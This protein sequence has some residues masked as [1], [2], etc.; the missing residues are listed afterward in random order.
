MTARFLSHTEISTLQA[1]EA[2][3]AFRYTGRLTGGQALRRKVT[4]P[5]LRDGRAW[6]RGWAAWHEL[7]GEGRIPGSLEVSP[8]EAGLAAIEKALD[9]NLVEQ[10]DHVTEV[11]KN[12]T[13]AGELVAELEVEH[14]AAVTDLQAML[15]H[16][17]AEA[18][19]L[20]LHDA[21][22]KIDVAIPSRTGRRKSSRYRFVCYLDGLADDV[23]G[24]T[25]LAECKLRDQLTDP[26]VIELDRQIRW[27][28]WAAREATGVDVTGAVVDER[29]KRAPHPPKLVRSKSKQIVRVRDD[30]RPDKDYIEVPSHDGQQL[31]TVDAYLQLCA[32]HRVAPAAATRELL[33]EK[34]WQQ[35]TAIRFRKGELDEAGDELVSIAK[36]VR[37]LDPDGDRYPVR[38]PGPRTCGGCG[39]VDIC[40]RPDRADLD[41]DFHL[42]PPKRDR[43][44]NDDGRGR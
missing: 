23:H 21:E 1:C 32:D 4:V 33:A 24:R 27:S 18:V 20:T 6:G 26:R 13:R 19:P 35:R 42:R 8:L 11:V 22:L 30:G 2:R 44:N 3:H 31:A 41:Y 10:I 9:E 39:F 43:G 40:A 28:A 7:A 29:W 36:Q 5:A 17:A 37:Q 14:L 38:A 25:W 34:T 16:Y 12:K 15:A